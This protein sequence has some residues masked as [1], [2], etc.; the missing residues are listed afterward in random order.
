MLNPFRKADAPSVDGSL[1]PLLD[2]IHA[3]SRTL[4]TEE[5]NRDKVRDALVNVQNARAEVATQSEARI[6]AIGNRAADALLADGADDPELA[7]LREEQDVAARREAELGRT[8]AALQRRLDAAQAAVDAARAGH[9]DAKRSALQAIANEAVDEY[10]DES[11]GMI[12]ALRRVLALEEIVGAALGRQ[13]MLLAPGAGQAYVP[14][15]LGA[16]RDFLYQARLDAFPFEGHRRAVEA[17]RERLAKLG[18]VL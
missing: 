13:F 3:A 5:A 8:E 2:A 9:E 16:E 4:A 11:R 7:R 6:E 14:S 10:L 15:A 12:A 17:E 1:R 18:I